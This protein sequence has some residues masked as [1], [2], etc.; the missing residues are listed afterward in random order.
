[1][2]KL[3]Q[4]GGRAAPGAGQDRARAPSRGWLRPLVG[5]ATCCMLAIPASSWAQQTTYTCRDERGTVYTLWYPCPKGTKTTSASV[6]PTERPSRSD[7]SRDRSSYSAPAYVA[8]P[9]EYHRYMSARCRNL[10][11]AQR[12]GA[13]ANLAYDV[14]ARMRS[15][16]ERD[17]REEESAASM[18]LYKEQRDAR[19]SREEAQRQ[20]EAV[21]RE[22][23]EQAVRRMRQCAESRRI[24]AAKKART[25]L[26][27][28]EM[29]DLRR[30]EE[31]VASRCP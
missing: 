9:P 21:E 28:G 29:N 2:R 25:D 6:G 22:S 27:P 31:T 12:N 1:M 10:H 8:P 16:Y 5:L 23:E 30:F 7:S 19:K 26:T 18:R 15:E 14:A 17:C 3:H 13:S 4:R 11:D 20:A 24:L